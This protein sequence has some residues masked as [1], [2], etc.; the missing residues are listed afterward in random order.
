LKRKPIEG[1]FNYNI[2]CNKRY[3]ELFQYV[4]YMTKNRDKYIKD[5][6]DNEENDGF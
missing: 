5:G 1:T 3:E 4:P 6:D 2:L